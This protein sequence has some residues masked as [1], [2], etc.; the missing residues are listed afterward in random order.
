MSPYRS[1]AA[2]RLLALS[3]LSALM[4]SGASAQGIAHPE[5]AYIGLSV[6][7]SRAR[8]DAQ[9][10]SQRQL[11]GLQPSLGLSGVSSDG[12]DMGYRAFLGYQFNRQLGLELGVFDLGKFSTRA[13]LDPSGQL[14]GRLRV[15]GGS[16][17]L[18]GTVPL[19]DRLDLLLRGGAQYAR[20]RSRYEGSGSA[21]GASGTGSERKLGYKFGAGL[22]LAIS[23]SFLMRAEA[24]QY[25]VPSPL[26]S[27]MRVRVY[28]LSAVFPLGRTASSS[29][30]AATQPMVYR[31][32]AEAPAPMEARPAPVVI[33]QAPPP[34]PMAPPPPRRVS[35][36]AESLFAFDR[37]A[38]QPAGE[39]ALDQLARELAGTTFSVMVV[40]GHTDRLGS[41]A[42]NQTLSQQRAEVVKA[43]LVR[44]GGF[45]AS[46]ITTAGLGESQPVTQA[47]DCKA[48]M[49]MVALRACLQPDRRVDVEV[50]GT[51]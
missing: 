20:T 13:T 29:P 1:A 46:K 21:A 19:G 6:G 11:A 26:G 7:Q 33:V 37:W 35:F 2:R 49:P 31:P 32:M 51:R 12:R 25:R 48:S 39:A 18:V 17:D 16:L 27:Q 10:L 45:E 28:S 47:E 34:A 14:D 22:Q 50:S 4:A 5:R 36:S 30:A 23:P 41:E 42:Y 44:S 8:L 24:E 15:Q 3:T 40:E 38:L 9:A 43:Y